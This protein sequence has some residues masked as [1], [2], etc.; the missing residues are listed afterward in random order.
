M[1]DLFI[2][3][4]I[5]ELRKA[6]F[7]QAFYD[8][9]QERIIISPEYSRFFVTYEDGEHLIHYNEQSR[10]FRVKVR[11]ILDTAAMLAKA[12]DHSAPM[13]AEKLNGFR[14]LLEWNGMILAARDSAANGLTFVTWHYCYARQSMG[15]GFYTEDI[16]AAMRNFVG[17]SGLYPKDLLFDY[18]QL[19]WIRSCIEYRLEHD[20]G[21][22][23]NHIED[24]Q[25]I[26]TALEEV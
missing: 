8:K 21:L 10:E 11:S 18:S 9:E 6:R 3:I 4:F 5:A 24:M 2:R 19:A 7:N 16:A 1:N 22:F 23:P 12:W 26:L 14:K 13:R 25:S 15:S 17:R 20:G